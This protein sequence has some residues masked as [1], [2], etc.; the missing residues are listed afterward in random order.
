MRGRLPGAGDFAGQPASGL[1]PTG[2]LGHPIKMHAICS[3]DVTPISRTMR[4]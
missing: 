4:L 3:P 1:D 2:H